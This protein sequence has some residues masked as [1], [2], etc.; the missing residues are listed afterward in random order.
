MPERSDI[1]AH[2]ADGELVG[3]KTVEQNGFVVILDD[4]EAVGTFVAIALRNMGYK[5]VLTAEPD[6]FFELV[7]RLNP[8][9]IIIDLVMP[10]MDGLEGLRKL[11]NRTQARIIVT[12]G[13]EVRLLEAMRQSAVI[14][15]LD[16]VGRLSKP[17]RLSK[18]RDLM[19]VPARS[20]M[21]PRGDAVILKADMTPDKIRL[22]MQRGDFRLYLQDKV[23]CATGLCVGYEGLSRW[24][25][26]VHQVI[27]PNDFIPQIEAVGLEPELGEYILDLAIRHLALLDDPAVHI[28]VNLSLASFRSDGLREMLAA[29]RAPY[30]VRPGQIVLE[31]TE[32]GTSDISAADIHMLTRLRIDGYRL[33]IDD[34]GIG[35]SSIKRLVQLPFSEIKIDRIFVRDMA[36]SDE[37]RKVVRAIIAMAQALD[38]EVTGEGVEN[39]RTFALL[40]DMGCTMAQGYLFGQPR[41]AS[42]PDTSSRPAV[43]TAAGRVPQW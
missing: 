43:G 15:G 12:S 30:G 1:K 4:D 5:A 26:P 24:H 29:L 25:H 14:L 23:C 20:D 19:S 10:K 40:R 3:S 36:S 9:H 35:Q 8:T 6:H 11:A 2:L 17:F 41:P 39:P 33:A 27:Q 18:L 42:L 22:A 37:T 34:F 28:A 7:D 21:A 13:V 32:S 16:V 31:L 38:M